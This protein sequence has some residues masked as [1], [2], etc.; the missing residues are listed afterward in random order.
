MELD[1]FTPA[2]K[3]MRS[4]GPCT[5][6]ALL[7]FL[8]A[9]P[10]IAAPDA[11]QTLTADVLRGRALMAAAV[12][13]LGGAERLR[14][15]DR[16]HYSI[17]GTSL[18]GL[19]GFDPSNLEAHVPI[20]EVLTS[21]DFDYKDHMF[22]RRN[23]QVLPGGIR[24]DA[25]SYYKDGVVTD[26]YPGGAHMTEE[27]GS[28]TA[29]SNP[30][31]RIFPPLLGRQLL[32]DTSRATFVGSRIEGGEEIEI[33][34][35]AQDAGPPVRVR[36]DQQNRII[37]LEA[38]GTDP[39]RGDASVT[40]AYSG[41]RRVDGVSFPE[42][43]DIEVQGRPYLSFRVKD[44]SINPEFDATTFIAPRFSLLTTAVATNALGNGVYEIT[45]LNGGSFRVIFFDLGDSV[46]VFDAPGSREKSAWVAGEIRKA[47]G[48]K[49]IKYLILSHFH[50]DHI[51]GV[52]Y[53]VDNG[54][55]I[56]TTR[57]NASV[58]ARYAVR[59][60]RLR[61]D[62]PAAGKTP[63][64]LFLDNDY[65]DLK[66]EATRGLR[67]YKLPNA[68]HVKDMLMA[69]QPSGRLLV[70]ADLYVEL[71]G[72]SDASEA[73]FQW[74]NQ[75]NSPRVDWI[76]GTHLSKISTK[77]FEDARAQAGRPAQLPVSRP[78]RA[79]AKVELESATAYWLTSP[80]Y[81]AVWSHLG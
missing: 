61:P 38:T 23:L 62:L 53:Y 16:L 4:I 28:E 64:F 79:C 22:R 76:V 78:P 70:E 80:R 44:V 21:A 40:Y 65:L 75:R 30:S 19:Q 73:L 2:F 37:S 74:L 42:H 6:A 18:N 71:A 8:R 31:V 55:T 12:D 25:I 50:D 24:L 1:I 15:I 34:D 66:G 63:N 5:I 57:A 13:R 45:G 54:V 47:L 29:I 68:L 3:R 35:I 72:Y 20:G 49:P 52:G 51:A 36:L 33:V 43:V 81:G 39:L 7:V 10:A 56:V 27:K 11:S 59:D 48:P 9:V 17:D 26:T 60:S 41:E 67:V 77:E 46:A 14:K 32:E 69:Y 58:V